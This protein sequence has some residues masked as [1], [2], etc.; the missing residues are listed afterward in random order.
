MRV[1]DVDEGCWGFIDA[2]GR[3]LGDGV[4]WTSVADF[5]DGMA[6]VE[7]NQKFGFIN[8]DCV[9]VG[10]VRWTTVR[11]FKEG[12][13]AVQE[14][15][16]WGFIDHTNTLVIPCRYTEVNDFKKNTNGSLTCDVKKADGTWDVIDPTGKSVL[17][18]N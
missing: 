12:Y 18:G 14:N 7:L 10:E 8:T 11:S 16:R 15:G 5:S 3:V 17:Y 13:A 9:Q 1:Q 4:K 2:R 6:K